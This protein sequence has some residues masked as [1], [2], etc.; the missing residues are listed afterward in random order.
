MAGAGIF[1]QK[2]RI[3][4]IEGEIVVM[5]PIGSRY[6]G[7]VNRGCLKPFVPQKRSKESVPC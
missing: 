3:E 4:L 1:D 2:E 7:A 5:T 6:F